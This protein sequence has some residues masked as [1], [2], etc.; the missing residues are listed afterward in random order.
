VRTTRRS[1]RPRSTGHRAQ[2]GGSLVLQCVV[3]G[4]PIP[5]QPRRA[6]VMGPY[7]RH[8]HLLAAPDVTF[9]P[10][11]VACRARQPAGGGG[12]VA[13]AGQIQPVAPNRQLAH[14]MGVVPEF[15]SWR[16]LF[17]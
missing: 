17:T 8:R 1:T 3:G 4:G 9:A 5:S 10:R 15:I 6:G 2:L 13:A 11:E 16:S 7:Q 12:A 14:I